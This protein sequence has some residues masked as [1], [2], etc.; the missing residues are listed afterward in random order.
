MISCHH[1]SFSQFSMTFASPQRF[2]YLANFSSHH[3]YVKRDSLLFRD[4]LID[5]P[6]SQL[7]GNVAFPGATQ[8][9]KKG[10]LRSKLIS[11][12]IKPT[13]PFSTGKNVDQLPC[14]PDEP[15]GGSALGIG[16]ATRWKEPG[17]LHHH[18]EGRSP[19]THTNMCS[20]VLSR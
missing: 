17:S 19:N 8:L 9:L 7:R 3:L 6:G 12:T 15:A 18:A 14:P 5:E 10:G 20:I 13:T 11:K 1:R 2:N 16:R 4:C